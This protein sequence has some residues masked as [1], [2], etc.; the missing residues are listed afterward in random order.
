LNHEGRL[1]DERAEAVE[2][3]GELV[4]G[5]GKPEAEMRGHKVVVQEAPPRLLVSQGE[6]VVDGPGR[7][8]AR[9]EVEFRVV[10]VLIE[11]VVFRPFDFALFPLD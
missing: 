10:F 2:R 11:P 7:S 6:D 5:G 8:G 4:A 1:P 9:G 3:L